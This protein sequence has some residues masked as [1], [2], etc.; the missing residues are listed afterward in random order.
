MIVEPF[1]FWSLKLFFLP[2]LSALVR[3]SS[4]R[5]NCYNNKGIQQLSPWCSALHTRRLPFPKLCS[6][7]GATPIQW[8]V[9]ERDQRLGPH[10][11]ILVTLKG[12]PELPMQLCGFLFLFPQIFLDRIT[13]A[14]TNQYCAEYWRRSRYRFLKFSFDAIL[15][16]SVLYPLNSSC[17]GLPWFPC[18]SPRHRKIVRHTQVCPPFGMAW[19]FSPVS[20]TN[21]SP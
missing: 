19:N 7:R 17:L 16:S 10:A 3:T 15:S 8:L 20:C 2:W 13:H 1:L 9:D 11:P 12:Y 4:F 21:L 14:W 5:L 18:S 6:L